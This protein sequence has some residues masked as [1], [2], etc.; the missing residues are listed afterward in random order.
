MCS[1][2]L[3]LLL[4]LK[5]QSVEA[6]PRQRVLGGRGLLQMPELRNVSHRKNTHPRSK[7]FFDQPKFAGTDKKLLRKI[8][9]TDKPVGKHKKEDRHRDI[10]PLPL[11]FLQLLQQLQRPRQPLRSPTTHHRRHPLLPAYVLYRDIDIK[12]NRQPRQT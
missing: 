2:D 12:K 7:T 1:S 9:P 6:L 4:R 8:G 5:T 11:K 10:L 3:E